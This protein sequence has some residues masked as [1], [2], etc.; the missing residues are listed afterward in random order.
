MQESLEEKEFRF[1]SMQAES[2]IGNNTDIKMINAKIKSSLQNLSP[3]EKSIFI[4]RHYQEMK[5]SEISDSMNIAVGTVKSLLFRS[6]QK[7]QKSLAPYRRE[8]GL[9]DS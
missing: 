7:L 8:F 4:M 9:E 1:N 5:I 3:K 6:V 2:N